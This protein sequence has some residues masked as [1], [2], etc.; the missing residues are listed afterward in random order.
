MIYWIALLLKTWVIFI[1]GLYKLISVAYNYT[2][3][4]YVSV[5]LFHAIIKTMKYSK[6]FLDILIPLFSER[7]TS[8]I[9]EQA[10]SCSSCSLSV[11]CIII[12]LRNDLLWVGR[13]TGYWCII[14]TKLFCIVMLFSWTSCWHCWPLGDWH[15]SHWMWCYWWMRQIKP[16]Q[17]ALQRTTL[18]LKKVLTFELTVTL[19]NLNRFS[20]L[21]RCWKAYEICYKIHTTLPTS[22]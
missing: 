2:Y 13:W 3:A 6:P 19:S 11:W 7:C 10:F 8:L 14:T 16:A 1:A 22:P 15:D 21:L 18:C 5:R 20:K 12:R 9:V 17:L 4:C